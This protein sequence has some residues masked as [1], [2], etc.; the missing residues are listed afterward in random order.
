MRL[1]SSLYTPFWPAAAFDFL[2][3]EF[4]NTNFRAFAV[5]NF[6]IRL[7]DPIE[8]SFLSEGALSL[9]LCL[10]LDPKSDLR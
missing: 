5:L 7:A 6:A 2:V 9:P 1:L 8:S 3:E 10:S 4:C